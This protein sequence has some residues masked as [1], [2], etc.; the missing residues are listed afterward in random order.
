MNFG[1]MLSLDGKRRPDLCIPRISLQT[2][3]MCAFSFLFGSGND[4]ALITLI[5]LDFNAFYY[6]LPPFSSLYHTYSPYG[7]N[8]CL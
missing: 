4:Q 6:I 2:P 8:L 1:K 5:E 3:R 7:H